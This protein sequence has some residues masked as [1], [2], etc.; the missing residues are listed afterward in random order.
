MFSEPSCRKGD[1]RQPKE[2]V[3]VCPHDPCRDPRGSFE[4]VVMV[5]PVD[6]QNKKA[7]QIGDKLWD[8]ARQTTQTIGGRRVQFQ[9]HDGDNDGKDPVAKSL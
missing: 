6:R 9:D 2:K 1:E 5:I 3:H 7:K 8:E 4:K